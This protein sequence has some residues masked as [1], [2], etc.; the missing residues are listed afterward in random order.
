MFDKFISC[1][2]DSNSKVNLFAL[3]TLNSLTGLLKDYLSAV[4]NITIPTVAQNL[5]SKNK[6]IH[7]TAA[8]VLDS[9]METLG[10]FVTNA[11]LRVISVSTIQDVERRC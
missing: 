5:S 3:Q 4:V 1:L 2:K 10:R 11:L 8:A 9:F 6:D 7:E